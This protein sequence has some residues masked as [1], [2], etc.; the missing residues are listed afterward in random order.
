[1]LD[2][3]EAVKTLRLLRCKNHYTNN[4]ILQYHK[5]LNVIE[6]SLCEESCVI[7][8]LDGV[9]INS[10]EECCKAVQKSKASS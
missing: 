5:C 7:V 3:N 1:M 10:P 8:N 6:E 4:E 2:V 9:N